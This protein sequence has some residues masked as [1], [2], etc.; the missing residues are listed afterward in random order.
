[1]GNKVDKKESEFSAHRAVSVEEAMAFAE[2]EGMD[3]VETSALTSTKVE[4]AF[5]RLVLSVARS[6]P[7]IKVHL[8]LTGLPLGWIKAMPQVSP[9]L[10]PP[11]SSPSATMSE[12]AEASLPPPPP[13]VTGDTEVVRSSSR[14]NSTVAIENVQYCNYWTGAIVSETP[15]EPANTEMLFV[16]KRVRASILD[17][18]KID[19]KNLSITSVPPPKAAGRCFCIIL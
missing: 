1:M 9:P 8:E 7:D 2:E 14:S 17:K 11:A 18:S 19:D 6:L 3:F 10:T 5:R 15:T 12:R 4:V 13:V 16:S